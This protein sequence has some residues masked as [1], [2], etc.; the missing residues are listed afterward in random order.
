MAR[1]SSK[2]SR[3]E[4]G[5]AL[6]SAADIHA[7][8]EHCD[9]QSE[10]PDLIASLRSV[11]EMW[12]NWRRMERTGLRNAQRTPIPIEERTR[13]FRAYSSWLIPGIVQTQGYTRAIL[14]AI[15]ARRRLPNDVEAAVAVRMER[16]QRLQDNAKT[17]AVLLEESVLRAGLGGA[18]V[19]TGQL[20][21][22]IACASLPNVSLGIVPAV[23]SR[24]RAWPVEDF[25]IYDNAQANVELVSGWLTITQPS[26]VAMYSQA[27]TE[28]SELAVFGSA[29]RALITHAIEAIE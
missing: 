18:Q 16:Q 22:L 5:A 4:H 11:E 6:P 28:L 20:G 15:A 2:V 19:M 25:W 9:A 8:C 14:T 23:P 1:H 24:D 7:W 10:T 26:E 13:R 17:W 27:F 21:H 12:T 29:A 3:I